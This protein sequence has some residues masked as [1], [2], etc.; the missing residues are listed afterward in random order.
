[1]LVLCFLCVLSRSVW[2][3]LVDR[4]SGHLAKIIAVLDRNSGLEHGRLVKKEHGRPDKQEEEDWTRKLLVDLI[5]IVD[6]D[7]P[8]D[9][10]AAFQ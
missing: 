6:L 5:N 2:L 4:M 8:A 3:H 9:E 1:M 10:S 7:C